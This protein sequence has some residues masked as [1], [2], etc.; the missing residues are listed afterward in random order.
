MLCAT[1]NM[2]SDVLLLVWKLMQAPCQEAPFFS[3]L[4]KSVVRA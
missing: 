4:E 3:S 1:K 2:Q